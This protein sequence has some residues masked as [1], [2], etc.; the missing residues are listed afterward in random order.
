MNGEYV[1]WSTGPDLADEDDDIE[2][3]S[4]QSEP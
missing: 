3:W 1:L 2:F 4:D